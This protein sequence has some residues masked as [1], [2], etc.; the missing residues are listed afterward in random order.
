MCCRQIYEAIMSQHAGKLTAAVKGS[1]GGKGGLAASPSRYSG[2]LYSEHAEAAEQ[3]L[4]MYAD[5][6]V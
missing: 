2:L 6:R 1:G 5:D 3:Q 4:P